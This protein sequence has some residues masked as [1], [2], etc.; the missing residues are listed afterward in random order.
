MPT[1][2][3]RDDRVTC[4]CTRVTIDIV[5]CRVTDNMYSVD[6]SYRYIVV[7]GV[8]AIDALSAGVFYILCSV[9]T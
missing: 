1:I 2:H 9:A 5:D 8:T 7:D 4:T 3:T 6:D